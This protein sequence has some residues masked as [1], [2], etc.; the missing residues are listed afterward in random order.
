ME[1][2]HDLGKIYNN[3]GTSQ[4]IIENSSGIQLPIG[5]TSE[6][7][8][9]PDGVV[10]RNS[11]TGYVEVYSN[12]QWVDIRSYLPSG[13]VANDIL[14]KASGSDYDSYWGKLTADMAPYARQIVITVKNDTLS[15]IAKG[16]PV[17]QSGEAG[18]SWVL[19]VRPADSADPSKMPAIGVLAEDLV[20]AQ[21]GSLIVLGEIRDV[22]TSAFSG[23]DLIYVAPGGGYTNVKPTGLNVEVQFLG[24]VTK[25]HATNGGGVVTGT[26]TVDLFRNDLPGGFH[27]WTGTEWKLIDESISTLLDVTL[28]DLQSGQFLS[29]DGSTWIN[30]SGIGS[31]TSHNDLTD[32]SLSDQHPIAAIT[33]LQSSLDSKHPTL[34]SGTNLQSINGSSILTS[35]NLNLQPSLVSGTNIKTVAGFNLL[36]SGDQPLSL[37]NLSDTVI[38]SPING[39]LLQHNG[40][41]WVNQTTIPGSASTV[42]NTWVLISGNRYYQDFDHSLGT[43]NLVFS[44]FNNN[45]NAMIG[46][47]SIVILNINTVRVTVIGNTIPVRITAL[48][49]G[50]TVGSVLT[51]VANNLQV[52]NAGGTVSIQSELLANRPT[53]GV[54]G[55]IF[56]T[57]DTKTLYRDNGTSWDV[58]SAGTSGTLISITYYANSVDSPITPD[59]AVNSL[60]PAIADPT[61]TA[62]DVRSFSNTT[63]QGVAFMT[64]PPSGSISITITTIGRAATAPGTISVV[65][66]RL[67]FRAI[68]NGTA[69]G[70]WSAANNMGAIS[71]PTNAFYKTDIQTFSLS[72][73]GLTPGITYLVE[74]TR[75]VVPT[76]GTNLPSAWYVPSV[77]VAYS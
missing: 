33:N 5:T 46:V 55:R 21:E 24:I 25:V 52:I 22:D 51:N 75:N 40:T 60:A 39:H 71:I 15:T 44:T 42:L 47:D 32:R 31:P 53:A 61:N 11:D 48:A 38:T 19:L 64:T 76:S 70:A 58:I 20:P 36:G 77:T 7:P 14:I 41:N 73:F 2:D 57:T 59:F 30:V 50:L 66:P 12:N 68:P 56:L 34:I 35:G 74:F 6:R 45:T 28:T 23:G 13:G 26:G 3:P 37:D 65:Q 16:T 63:E 10:R 49:N 9:I 43:A 69:M 27:G 72:S 4:L 1:I 67:Y 62:L 29:Y 8:T 17:Y 18:S 54:N